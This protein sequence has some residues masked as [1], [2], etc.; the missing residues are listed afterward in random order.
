[1]LSVDRQFLSWTFGL[2]LLGQ[3]DQTNMTA[4]LP[5]KIRRALY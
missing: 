3:V 5:M 1:M 4:F 2:A